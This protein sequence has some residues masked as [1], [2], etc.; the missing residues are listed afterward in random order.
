MTRDQGASRRQAPAVAFLEGQEITTIGCRRCGTEV[1]GVNGRY[2]CGVC[3]WVNHWSEG[4]NELPTAGDD[5]PD[6]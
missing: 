3:G 4:H 5:A 2:A 1:A 6:A